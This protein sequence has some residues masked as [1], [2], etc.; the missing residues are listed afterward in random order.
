MQH[1]YPVAV[2]QFNHMG[3]DAIDKSGHPDRG[4]NGT[5]ND[6]T[7]TIFFRTSEQL[8]FLS[9][10]HGRSCERHSKIIQQALPSLN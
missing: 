1:P 8:P 6:M 4:L 10:Q 7:A 9:L 3:T 2:I 5:A